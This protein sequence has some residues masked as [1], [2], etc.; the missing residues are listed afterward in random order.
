MKAVKI[1]TESNQEK[2]EKKINEFI[3]SC[4]N[5]NYDVCDIKLTM[6][7]VNS[8]GINRKT[9]TAMIIYQQKS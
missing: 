2:I 4:S 1:I 5:S 6:T 3:V 9:Y 7:E 8:V